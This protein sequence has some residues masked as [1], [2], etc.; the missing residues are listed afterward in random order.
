M[1]RAIRFLLV[2]AFAAGTLGIASP[3][4]ADHAHNLITPGTE[5]VD[6]GHGQT[7]QSS[8]AGCH[9][10]HD[11]MHTGTPG[12]FAFANENNP[13]EVIKTEDGTCTP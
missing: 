3:A 13:V 7:S 8:G 4:S 10:F 9:K 2:G 6:I 12:T 5:V 11:N 1:K